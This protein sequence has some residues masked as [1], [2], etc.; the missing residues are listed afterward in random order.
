MGL[1][2][3]QTLVGDAF[4]NSSTLPEYAT[5]EPCITH[6][7]K[8]PNDERLTSPDLP[9]AILRNLTPRPQLFRSLEAARDHV[10][11]KSLD[12]RQASRDASGETSKIPG[13]NEP[14]LGDMNPLPRPRALGRSLTDHGQSKPPGL[15][16]YPTSS[17]RGFTP[18]TKPVIWENVP[19]PLNTTSSRNV[20]SSQ[21]SGSSVDNIIGQYMQQQQSSSVAQSQAAIYDGSS[22]TAEMDRFIGQNQD[23]VQ[24]NLGTEPSWG[25]GATPALEGSD[26]GLKSKVFDQSAPSGPPASRAPLHP[27]NP[28][29]KDPS[30]GDTDSDNP[31]LWGSLCPAGPDA[32]LRDTPTPPID[33]SQ[34]NL[35]SDLGAGSIAGSETVSVAESKVGPLNRPSSAMHSVRCQRRG[36]SSSANYNTHS[37]VAASEGTDASDADEDPFKYDR[38]GPFLQPSRERVVS[39]HLRKVSGLPRE[40]TATVYSQD[41]TPSRT[42]YGD[43]ATDYFVRD[44]KPVSPIPDR[45]QYDPSTVQ[46]PS[47]NP[48]AGSQR[49]HHGSA[50]VTKDFY[51]INS[52]NPEW[53]SGKPDMV[54]VP[55]TKK[56][57]HFGGAQRNTGV[58][59]SSQSDQDV[60]LEALRRHEGDKRITGNTE[61]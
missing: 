20:S 54:R 22:S 59:P 2:A 42:F 1:E 50:N 51:N 17:V 7:L 36:R 46:A 45:L 29:F 55:V 6:P 48:F 11:R 16:T 39:A 33:H 3:E 27:S 24:V 37:G 47:R 18:I 38:H 23:A 57:N 44:G 21:A 43:A 12:T 60:G 14:S 61:D 53:T 13:E 10:Y 5:T 9:D 34:A 31:Q 40:S 32:L 56:G 58:D 41:G 4:P 30:P 49:G 26:I 28:F 52:I 19:R 8:T 25:D 35:G 15:P